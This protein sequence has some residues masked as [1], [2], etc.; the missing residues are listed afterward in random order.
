MFY[1]IEYRVRFQ[2]S[3][4]K[5]VFSSVLCREATSTYYST[6]AVTIA[7]SLLDSSVVIQVVKMHG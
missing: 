1:S 2:C 4:P 7:A 5:V 3:E 6:A